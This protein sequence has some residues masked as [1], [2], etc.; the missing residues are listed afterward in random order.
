MRQAVVL[1]LL[2]S[3]VV[4][5][6]ARPNFT[7]LWVLNL[8]RSALELEQAR[9]VVSGELD[10]THADPVFKFRRT[11]RLGER[12]SKF[13]YELRTDGY[14]VEGEHGGRKFRSRLAWEGDALVYT[15]EFIRTEGSATDVVRYS[16]ADR[17]R[18]LR[19]DET[20]DG[21]QLKYH[22]VWVFERRD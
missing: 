5:G 1:S 3:A 7:G 15:S 16:L 17:G 13:A 4:L 9:K 6:A 22:N 12:D 19:A 14:E 20:F 2:V 18:T 8:E 11:F 21:P 10:I